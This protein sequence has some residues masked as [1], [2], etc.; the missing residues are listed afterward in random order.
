[1]SAKD[2]VQGKY[3]EPATLVSKVVITY[4][5]EGDPEG[6]E[7]TRTL[8]HGRGGEALNG[9]VWSGELMRKV[10]YL[11]RDGSCTEAK[12]ERGTAAWKVYSSEKEGEADG[13]G[14]CFWL[15]SPSCIWSEY[16]SDS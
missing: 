7:R 12:K 10:G 9:L 1:M 2:V 16:C 8:E 15:H 5:L 11:E 3:S 4:R 6:T 13:A 14:N